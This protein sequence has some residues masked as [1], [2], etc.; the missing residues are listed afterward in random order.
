[1]KAPFYRGTVPYLFFYKAQS[2]R[3]FTAKTQRLAYLAATSGL[4]APDANSKSIAEFIDPNPPGY[5]HGLM[6]RSDNPMPE[7]IITLVRD[8]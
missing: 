1:M 8:L 3:V 4:L 7:L 6:G 5:M 2:S